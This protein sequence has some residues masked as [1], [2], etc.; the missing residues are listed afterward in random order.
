M[1]E[2]L[3][4]M[5]RDVHF[6]GSFSA[7]L[8]YYQ[9]EGIG[10][11]DEID[12]E[13]ILHLKTLEEQNIPLL[14]GAEEKRQV[15]EGKEAYKKVQALY[16][17]PDTCL[18][19]DLILAEEEVF[20][21]FTEKHL[22]WLIDLLHDS[23]FSDPL[24]PGYGLAPARAAKV[25]GKLQKDE[26]TKALFE[27]LLHIGDEEVYL[28]EEILSALAYAK[29]FLIER[30]K[31]RPITFDNVAA[32][33]ALGSTTVDENLKRIAAEE[34]ARLCEEGCLDAR[35]LAYLEALYE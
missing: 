30:L 18:F 35:L 22:P 28:Q 13:D 16:E 4:L 5:H 27:R 20:E 29:D 14:L 15:L 33:M 17:N 21:G 10:A 19:A 25:L 7:M 32:A 11:V 1:D 6:S 31:S 24:Y 34:H 2:M 3:I 12:P 23:A 26:G 9:A 8:E